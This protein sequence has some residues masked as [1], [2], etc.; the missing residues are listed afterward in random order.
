MGDFN[1]AGALNALAS[2]AKQ[3]EAVAR[4][5][6]HSAS[7]SKAADRLPE[8]PAGSYPTPA[9]AKGGSP[10]VPADPRGA[11][12]RPGLHREDRSRQYQDGQHAKPTK[13]SLQ[14]RQG[15]PSGD[16]YTTSG[17][18]RAMQQLADREHK[19]VFKGRK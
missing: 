1:P 16:G 14:D 4:A 13:G 7:I 19:R 8:K 11:A 15:S 9:Q 5:G 2:I 10:A 17:L 18:D 3:S 6:G 12:V